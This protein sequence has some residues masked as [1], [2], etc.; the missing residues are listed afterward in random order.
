MKTI[1]WRLYYGIKNW[2]WH[3]IPFH[4]VYLS[5]ILDEENIAVNHDYDDSFY[6]ERDAYLAKAS[7][8]FNELMPGRKCTCDDCDYRSNDC[9]FAFDPYNT[10]G[11][12]LAGD[13]LAIK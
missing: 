3:Y 10:D 6:Q 9:E 12:C 5:A 4:G 8:T 13:C 2:M 11:D 7:N 1:L